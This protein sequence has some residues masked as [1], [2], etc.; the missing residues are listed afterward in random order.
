VKALDPITLEILTEVL[1]SIVREMR[2]TVFRTARSVA[3]YEAKDFS[4]GLFDHTA[5]VVAQS[6]DI[7]AHV[8]PLPWSVH[9]AMAEFKDDLAPG[10]VILLNDPYRGGTHLNDVTLIYPVF[11]EGRLILFPA[12]REHWADVGGMV[13]GSLSGEATSI[14]Q[15]GLRIPPIKVVERGQVNRAAMALILGNMRVPDER[16]GDFHAGLAACKTAERR[17]RESVARYGLDTLLGAIRQNLDR[18]EARMRERI[19]A[20]PDGEY[21]YEDYLETFTEGRLEPLLLPLRLSIRGTDIV[22]DF[23]GASPQV[24]VPVNSTLAVSAASV[25]IALKSILDPAAPLNQGSFRPITVVAPEG[26][27]VNVRPPAPAG[28]HGAIRK[29]V[30]AVTVGALAQVVPELVAGDLFR[31]SFHNLVGGVH[32]LT[33]KEFVHYEWASGGNG[34]FAEDDGPSAMASID[35]GDL[36][37]V[38]S[39]EVLETRFPLRLEWSALATDSGGDGRQRGGL[40]MQRG[41]RL[42][43][44]VATYSVLADGAVLP[45]YGILGGG[46][47]IPVGSHVIRDGRALQFPTPGKVGGFRLLKDDVLVLQSAG[48]GGYGDPLERSVERVL[49]DRREGYIS[50]DRC[51]ERYGVVVGSGGEV[52]VAATA[53]LRRELAARRLWLTVVAVEDGLYLRGAVSVR[54]ICP[55]SPAD[56]ARMGFDD[57]AIVELLGPGGAP[58]RAWVAVDG[59]VEPGTVPLDARGRR[60]LGL[61]VGMPLHIRPL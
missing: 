2:A 48:G 19:G 9:S 52:D 59:A 30:I 47:G 13:P 54:R 1:I 29:R 6:E 25:F 23:T 34:A 42:L 24:P 39:T 27:I 28:S 32:P 26:T 45:A 60:V 21:D 31:T 50:P 15:E 36:N 35:W 11:E 3:I 55:L 56:A 18:S 8:V 5:E 53:A 20:L 49:S 40:S 58:L 22:A 4:C 10:D 7:G 57:G 12:V 41:I 46:S 43:A 38:Q 16:E 33:G 37:T 44:P 14:Y 61:D 51:R 17:I